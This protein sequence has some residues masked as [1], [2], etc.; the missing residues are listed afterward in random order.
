MIAPGRFAYLWAMNPTPQA[1]TL[2]DEDDDTPPV[3]GSWSRVY[4]F[5]LVL[6]LLLILGF[7]LFSRAYTPAA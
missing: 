2:A 4:L 7:Y 5:V 6:H 1:T 3:L